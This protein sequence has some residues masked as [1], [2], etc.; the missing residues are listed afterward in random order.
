MYRSDHLE[1]KWTLGN[2]EIGAF[3]FQAAAYCA[4]YVTKKIYGDKSEDY[5]QGLKPEYLVVSKGRKKPG[6]DIPG[7]GLGASWFIK[8]H[9]DVFPEDV[10]VVEGK[11]YPVPRYYDELYEK[12]YPRAMAKVKEKR[13]INAQKSEERYDKFNNNKI[14]R[15]DKREMCLA[16]RTKRLERS[17]ENQDE[18]IYDL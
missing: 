1:S 14:R 3:N 5:Y 18:S 12:M 16:A 17:Y 4:R 9:T 8:N 10:C 7:T 15:E 13:R 2:A 11:R 6:E